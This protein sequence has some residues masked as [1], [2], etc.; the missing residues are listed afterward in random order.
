ML[1][2]MGLAWGTL[3]PGITPSESIRKQCTIAMSMSLF[4]FGIGTEPTP[5]DGPLGHRQQS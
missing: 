3:G 1:E 5:A 4:V 2:K